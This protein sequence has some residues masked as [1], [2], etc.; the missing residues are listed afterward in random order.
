MFQLEM[1]MGK[2]VGVQELYIPID[3]ASNAVEP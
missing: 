3:R 1:E 2:L